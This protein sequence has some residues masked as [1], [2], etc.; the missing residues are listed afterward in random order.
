MSQPPQGPPPP[1]WGD[2]APTGPPPKKSHVVEY[3]VGALVGVIGLML[4]SLLGLGLA[5][6]ASATVLIWSGPVLTL[7]IY[8][9][10]AV[11]RRTRYWGIGLL[12]GYFLASILLGGAC[13]ALLAAFSSGGA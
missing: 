5:D 6:S 4:L 7:A 11:S 12:I 3:V 1:G 10:V 9:A 13:I 2:A 8:I